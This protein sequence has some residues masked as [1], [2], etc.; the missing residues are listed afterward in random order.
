MGSA[1]S[2]IRAHSRAFGASETSLAL[3]REGHP[4]EPTRLYELGACG[5]RL[6]PL[7][8]LSSMGRGTG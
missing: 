6:F 4:P 1:A 3:Y 8:P 7:S 2:Q 5:K